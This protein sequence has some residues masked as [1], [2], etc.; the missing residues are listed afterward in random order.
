MKKTD[1]VVQV[2]LPDN[3]VVYFRHPASTP[4]SKRDFQLVA[5]IFTPLVRVSRWKKPS[6]TETGGV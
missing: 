3:S 4:P 6:A 2:T 1:V 5:K